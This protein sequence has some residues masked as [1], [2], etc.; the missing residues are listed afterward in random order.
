M[1]SKQVPAWKALAQQIDA[2][3]YEVSDWEATFLES[4]LT[5][6]GP[7]TPTQLRVLTLMVEK[8]L[9]LEAAAELH[10]QQRFWGGGTPCNTP[11]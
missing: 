1:A 5:W 9:G 4:M 2:G 6:R 10:G 3:A 8:Y 11:S 7:I